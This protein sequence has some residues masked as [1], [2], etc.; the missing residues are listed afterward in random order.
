[1]HGW[2]S[3][4]KTFLK[5]G[6]KK[7]LSVAVHFTDSHELVVLGGA[8]ARVGVDDGGLA[9]RLAAHVLLAVLVPEGA[10]DLQAPAGRRGVQTGHRRRVIVLMGAR[11]HRTR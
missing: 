7:L 10:V 11:G 4:T 9:D 8:D 3:G 5:K 1:M 2:L 6:K